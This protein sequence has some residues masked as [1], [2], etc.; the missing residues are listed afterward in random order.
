MVEKLKAYLAELFAKKDAL[1]AEDHAAEIEAEVASY[2]ETL[3]KNVEA[4][5]AEAIAKV[6]SDIECI[7]NIIARET[8]TVEPVENVLAE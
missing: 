3:V 1:I 4:K 6:D 2:R 8:E 7:T 5:K